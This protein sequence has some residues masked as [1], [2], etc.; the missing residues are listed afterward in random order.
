M[1]Q[2]VNTANAEAES[3][4][5]DQGISES[6]FAQRR[7][8]QLSGQTAPEADGQETLNFEE[9][10]NESVDT[11]EESPAAENED[12]LS[13]FKLDDL[14]AEQIKALSKK[15][16]SRAVDRYG[17][18]TARAKGAEEAL[19]EYRKAHE[20]DPLASDKVED[21]PFKDITTLQGLK[22]QAAEVDEIIE[23]A[24]DLLD[25]ADDYGASDEITE[26][27]GKPMTKAEVR[28][29]LK[30]ARKSRKKYLPDQYQQLSDKHQKAQARQEYGRKA[31]EEF[32]W[33]QGDDNDT[34]KKYIEIAN[35]ESLKKVYSDNPEL[36]YLLAHAVDNMYQRKAV[37]TKGNA[38]PKKAK[39]PALTPN[40]APSPSSAPSGKSERKPAKQLKELADRFKKS[41]DANDFVSL[42]AK[43]IQNQI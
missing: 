24:E 31:I 19:A 14:S 22:E 11:G 33:L 15:L 30:N 9:E 1:S 25:D 21:N 4:S 10:D 29:A 23:W 3:Q 37:D 28:K 36:P 35:N 32:G 8:N 17:E 20:E 39:R 38:A 2:E 5:V 34:R 12:V 26:V 6:E 27:D 16:G 18:L 40:M 41:G 42:R 7:L 13:Q 43:Q